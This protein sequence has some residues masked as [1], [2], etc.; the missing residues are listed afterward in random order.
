[1][2]RSIIRQIFKYS[3]KTPNSMGSNDSVCVGIDDVA[4]HFPRLYMDMK[5][6]ADLRGEDYG[7]LNK[8]LGLKAMSIPDVHEEIGRA[9]V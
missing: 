4:I 8:G 7:K 2:I 9:H 6:F 3:K 1:M 5:D